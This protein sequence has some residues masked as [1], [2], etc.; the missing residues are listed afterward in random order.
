MLG[1]IAVPGIYGLVCN[2]NLHNNFEMMRDAMRLYSHYIQDDLFIDQKIA[3]SRVHIGNIGEMT[4]PVIFDEVLYIWVEG[5]AYNVQEVAKQINLPFEG[6]SLAKL[7]L[8]AEKLEKLNDCLNILDGYFCAVIY[9][10]QSKIVKIFSDRYGMRL[11]YWY[12]SDGVFAWGSEVKAILAVDCV[13]KSIDLSSL[14]CF[15]DLG[16]LMGEHTWFSCIKLIKPATVIE[17]NIEEDALR[18]W[19][20][21]RWSEIKPSLICFD[22]AVSRLGELFFQSVSKRFDGNNRIGISLSGGLDSRAI[23]AAVNNLYPDYDGYIYTFGFPNCD[24]ILIAEK[25]ALLSNW[26]H[27]KFYLTQKN[28]F[29]PRIKSVW[30]TDGMLDIMHMHG[31]EFSKIIHERIDIN[32]NGYCGDAVMGGAFLSVLPLNSRS[33]EENTLPFYGK[34]SKEA[35]ISEDFYNIDHVEPN[36]YMNRVRRFTNYGT[37]NNLPW[38]H[39]RKPFFD[40]ELVEFIFSLPDEYRLHN[41]LYSA[42]LQRVFPKFFKKIPWQ[43]T[44]KPV[45]THKTTSLYFKLQNRIKLL[46]NILFNLNKN[47]SYVDYSQLIRDKEIFYE[48]QTIIN[49]KSIKNVRIK[50]LSQKLLKEYPENDFAD[51]TKKILRI[52]TIIAYFDNPIIKNKI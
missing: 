38:I 9:D 43:K 7:L 5:E 33:S 51:N 4:S 34:Y 2:I 35:N 19:Y 6:D 52:A 23:F 45:S 29:S 42:M 16:Y 26:T 31:C 47:N 39:Q 17:Y 48:I 8:L 13:D 21:W 20:Y 3:A 46:A 22:D 28:W 49:D 14:D 37:V 50:Y 27:E 40:N 1:C 11:L 44:G 36:I 12:H 41:K 32:L 10:K 18:Q 24:D 15:I 30:V 25:V